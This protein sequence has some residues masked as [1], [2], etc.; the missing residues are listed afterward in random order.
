MQL[1]SCFQKLLR[2][3]ENTYVLHRETVN[4]ERLP[5][6]VVGKTNN[7]KSRPGLWNIHRLALQ[8]L[9]LQTV[10]VNPSFNTEEWL[11]RPSPPRWGEKVKTAEAG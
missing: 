9:K 5:S 6:A 8:T 2:A 11:W 3:N 1:L 10:P 4:Q 7:E